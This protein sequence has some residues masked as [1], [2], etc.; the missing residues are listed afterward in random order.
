MNSTLTVEEKTL[1]NISNVIG[2]L[3]IPITAVAAGLA[4]ALTVPVLLL[5]ENKLRTKSM[6]K[7]YR[8]L[9]L[10]IIFETVSCFIAFGFDNAFT[11]YNEIPL[12]PY[13]NRFYRLFIL[14]FTGRSLWIASSFIE[15]TLAVNRYFHLKK[16]C[17][18]FKKINIS[19]SMS[20]IVVVSFSMHV[21]IVFAFDI[22]RD[23]SSSL[24]TLTLNGMGRTLEFYA[25]LVMIS[26]LILV[27]F[28]IVAMVVNVLLVLRLKTLINSS[29]SQR[30]I[31]FTKIIIFQTTTFFISRS[32]MLAV[33]LI[34][35]ETSLGFIL[36]KNILTVFGYFISGLNVF[37]IIGF[38]RSSF[39]NYPMIR[40][41]VIFC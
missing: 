16:S 37:V 33:N 19:L 10:K 41:L 5:I 21:P 2:T 36:A 25:Y 4:N 6:K 7:N 17:Q 15:L 22:A 3:V 9:I 11:N 12:R 38:D 26:V 29:D 32:I 13:F 31:I 28:L 39:E 14:D 24:Y 20:L 1:L 40:R 30:Q 18:W 8:L 23:T 27:L 35:I 34:L